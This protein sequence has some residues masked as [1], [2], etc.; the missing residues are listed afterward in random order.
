MVVVKLRKRWCP[1][2]SYYFADT[3]ITYEDSRVL[4]VVINPRKSIGFPLEA[5]AW[6]QIERIDD[7]EIHVRTASDM[8]RSESVAVK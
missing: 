1:W 6:Y 7:E 5:L 2:V 8:E 4:R 3:A